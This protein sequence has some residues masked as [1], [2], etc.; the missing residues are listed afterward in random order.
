MEVNKV[1]KK[2]SKE[3]LQS[4]FVKRGNIRG[5][6]NVCKECANKLRKNIKRTYPTL[7]E[8]CCI[9]CNNTKPISE[10]NKNKRN[11]LGIVK[12]CKECRSVKSKKYY[13][14]NKE[15]IK[16]K[17]NDYYIQNKSTVKE[18]RKEYSKRRLQTDIKYKIARNLRNR[19]YY[20][21]QFKEWKKNTH[22]S[23]YI[24][25]DLS[26]LKQHLES[27]FKPG[28]N[29]DNYGEWHIDHIVPLSKSENEETMYKLC[30]YTNLRPEWSKDNIKKHNEVTYV[31]KQIDAVATHPFLL[32][33]HYAKRI[34]SISYAFGLFANDALVGVVTYGKTSSPLTANA[35]VGPDYSNKVYELNRLCLLNN[36]KNEASILVG[37]SL[38]L[39]PKDTIILSFADSEQGHLGIVYQAANFRYYGL[40]EAKS[41]IA[42]KSQPNKHALSIY[43]ES[44][45]EENRINY[46]KEKYGDD[47]YWK[48]R[49]QKHRYVYVIGDKSLY[50][51]I[52]Y[53]QY[54]YPKNIR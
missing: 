23:Q 26:Q 18:K 3:K 42:L 32:N 35:L 50:S 40:T 12:E 25:C 30:H 39:L 49:S 15:V 36:L 29:W 11:P 52:K 41:E 20:A 28:M 46:L 48:K 24:G 19:L 27:L 9:V 7:S 54:N 31:V 10:F 33:I 53:K 4:L 5:Y 16:K 14:R 6:G 17:T 8:Y 43:D 2:C 34:P 13:N 1:C 38:K 51:L 44:K 21:L 22:F 45:G 47:L 37:R